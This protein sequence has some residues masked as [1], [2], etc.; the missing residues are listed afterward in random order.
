MA[1]F[2]NYGTTEIRADEKQYHADAYVH[3]I[4]YQRYK[5]EALVK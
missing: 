4:Q 1:G 3:Y 5:R 2:K